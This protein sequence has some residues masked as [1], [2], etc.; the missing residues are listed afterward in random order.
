MRGRGRRTMH[1][2]QRMLLYT[3]AATGAV[4]VVLVYCWAYVAPFLLAV[5][6]AAVIDP[7]VRLVHSATG[8]R[9]GA[10]VVLVLFVFLGLLLGGLTLAM[11]N[12]IVE[13]ERLLVHVPQYA[14]AVAQQVEGVLERVRHVFSRLPPP[15]D[16]L[17]F[18]D[19]KQAADAATSAVKNALGGLKAAPGA[20]F[21]VI[22]TGLAT[23]FISRDRHLLWGAVLSA[24]PAPWRRPIVRIRDEIVGGV[25]GMVRAQL[26]LLTMTAGV[27]VIGLAAAGVPYAWGLGL[28]AGVLDL[29][30]VVGPGGVF[31]PVAVVYAFSDRAATAIAVVVLWLVLVFLR[32]LLEPHVFSAQL[33]LHPVTVLAAV[34]VGVRAVGVAGFLIGPLALVVVKALLVV[35]LPTPRSIDGT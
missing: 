14:E 15:L 29:A 21:F 33:G 17:D 7:Y 20:A 28:A 2:R 27:S 18:F 10:A 19:S 35:V 22:V 13:L 6:L 3:L 11:V 32:Q 34:Y 1:R 30:P 4:A 8:M 31:V 5:F 9:R 12:L 26:I 16:S 23:F 24:L 25:L